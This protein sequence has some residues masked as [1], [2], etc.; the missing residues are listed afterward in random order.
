MQFWRD[1]VDK[2]LD[3][4]DKKVL[5]DAG[6]VSNAAME[7]QVRKIYE[8][9]DQRRKIAEA[10]KADEEDMEELKKLEEKVKKKK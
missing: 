9:F 1:N 3:F 2:I 7:K 6:S 4:Q 5:R 8:Q 10:K